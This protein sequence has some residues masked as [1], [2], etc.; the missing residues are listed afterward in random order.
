MDNLTQLC[1]QFA[2]TRIELDNLRAEIKAKF[3]SDIQELADRG[4]EIEIIFT[5]YPADS[6]YNVLV[7]P[8]N[9]EIRKL[10]KDKFEE[11]DKVLPMLDNMKFTKNDS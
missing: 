1:E 8:Y 9:D 3:K 2:A 7:T 6:D 10:V 4:F 11:V 5:C